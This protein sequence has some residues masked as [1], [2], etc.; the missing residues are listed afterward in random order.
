MYRSGD[1]DD[2]IKQL[3]H[4]VSLDANDATINDHLGD[5]YW[6]SGRQI[7]ARYQ[8]TRVLTLSPPDDLRATVQRKLAGGLDPGARAT[9]S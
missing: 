9:R 8:W 4:A 1:F 2:A 3:E 6:R 5:A 7:E